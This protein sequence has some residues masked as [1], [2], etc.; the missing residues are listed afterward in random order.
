MYQTKVIIKTTIPNYNEKFQF[1]NISK[2][3]SAIWRIYFSFFQGEKTGNGAAL[4]VA[5]KIINNEI[6]MNF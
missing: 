5:N 6:I 2:R 3:K 4:I 1:R